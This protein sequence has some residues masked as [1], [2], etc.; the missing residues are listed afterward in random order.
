M[1]DRLLYEGCSP[2]EDVRK[3][4][5]ALNRYLA[6]CQK[7]LI[8]EDGYFGPKTLAAV[9]AFQSAHPGIG[10]RDGSAPDG[11][12]GER[13][14]NALF[15]F[16]Y[17]DVIAI[18]RPIPLA[19]VP[20]QPMHIENVLKYAQPGPITLPPM[21]SL[22]PSNE[23]SSQNRLGVNFDAN[24]LSIS[25]G[26]TWQH[27][28][29][30][31]V[32]LVIQ[33]WKLGQDHSLKVESGFSGKLSQTYASGLDQIGKNL[34]LETFVGLTDEWKMG[35]F[36]GTDYK[37]TSQF[38]VTHPLYAKEAW[39]WTNGSL[40]TL[41]SSVDLS[42]KINLLKEPE[43]KESIFSVKPSFTAAGA[44]PFANKEAI[45]LS[46]TPKVK[47]IYTPKGLNGAI[48][49]FVEGSWK[50]SYD[51]DRTTNGWKSKDTF[52]SYLGISA[53]IIKLFSGNK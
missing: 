49:I 1:P 21:T 50:G 33:K 27:S 4:Q 38:N 23:K 42:T 36:L 10:K 52:S 12:V 19:I 44:Y 24:P 20:L 25:E 30:L 45:S 32:K 47:L 31:K 16:I 8:R 22:P 3:I 13:T 18:A 53:D 39:S 34:K 43:S 51:F 2:G 11:L 17:V 28:Y 14:R 40:P 15:P 35:E 48:D 6:S 37:L 26:A 5:Q 29:G 41:S 9:I 7:P 46:I